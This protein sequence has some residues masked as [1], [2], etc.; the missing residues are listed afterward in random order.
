LYQKCSDKASKHKCSGSVV[1]RWSAQKCL[2]YH[3]SLSALCRS[4]TITGLYSPRVSY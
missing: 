4:F 3:A 1:F 2:A